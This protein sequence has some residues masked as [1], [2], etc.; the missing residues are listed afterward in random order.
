MGTKRVRCESGFY[1]IT[2]RGNGKQIIFNDDEDYKRYLYYIRECNVSLN[3]AIVAYCLMSNHIHILIYDPNFNM[4]KLFQ[5]AHS[6]YSRYFNY[7]YERVGNMFQ[8]RFGSK[9]IEDDKQLCAV[10]RYVL[11]NPVESGICK[12]SEYKW[13]SYMLYG[14]KDSLVNTK[15]IEPIVGSFSNFVALVNSKDSNNEYRHF[16]VNEEILKVALKEKYNLELS[17]STRSFSKKQRN[18][19]IL[20]LYGKGATYKQI[21]RLTGISYGIVSRIV[22]NWTN[23]KNDASK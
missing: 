7:K 23:K 22:E 6:M 5:R 21:V 19:V 4:N 12:S 18:E 9:G 10:L 11:K 1:H 16:D 13:S 14:K 3:I 17:T 20:F 2:A 8:G 15:P